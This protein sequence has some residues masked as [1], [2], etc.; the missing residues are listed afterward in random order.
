MINK[1]KK[2]CTSRQTDTE[3]VRSP[4]EESDRRSKSSKVW[5][6]ITKKRCP[7]DKKPHWSAKQKAKRRRSDESYQPDQQGRH[8]MRKKAWE[9]ALWDKMRIRGSDERKWT[10]LRS[11]CVMMV[12]LVSVREIRRNKVWGGQGF[13]LAIKREKKRLVGKKG[14]L[15]V[16]LWVSERVPFSLSNFFLYTLLRFARIESCREK[17]MDELWGGRKWKHYDMKGQGQ[18]GERKERKGKKT[19]EGNFECVKEKFIYYMRRMKESRYFKVKI[20]VTASFGLLVAYM[21]SFLDFPSF[22]LHSSL[23]LHIYSHSPFIFTSFSCFWITGFWIIGC[24]CIGSRF[25]RVYK[26]KKMKKKEG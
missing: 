8:W 22:F 25:E 12:W 7:T 26:R 16:C 20:P 5:S 14:E 4:K 19:K 11:E 9:R 13:E 18:V 15:L 6:S 24:P 2:Q 17:G 10:Y 21:D 3:L 23:S 1:T